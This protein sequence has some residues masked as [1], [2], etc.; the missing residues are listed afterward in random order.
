MRVRNGL[1]GQW[2]HDGTTER[3]QHLAPGS[4]GAMLSTP[5]VSTGG[6]SAGSIPGIPCPWRPC[7]C[8]V[9]LAH[10]SCRGSRAA[11][12]DQTARA[13]RR[14][15]AR[16][17]HTSPAGAVWPATTDTDETRVSPVDLR[18]EPLHIAWV[19]R[20]RG[21]G[22]GRPYDGPAWRAG[23]GLPGA[24]IR[25]LPPGHAGRA[26]GRGGTSEVA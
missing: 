15:P 6:S 9:S 18:D 1:G 7:R 19:R 25:L 4:R 20:H 8:V 16:V 14:L 21:L 2:R 23:Q 11:T 17:A 3:M 22:R 24:F 13:R 5:A 26:R 12:A 10:I